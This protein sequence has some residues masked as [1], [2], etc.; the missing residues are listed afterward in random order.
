MIVAG[1]DHTPAARLVERSG[2]RIA[3]IMDV[4]PNSID[5]AVGFSNRRAGHEIGHY[6]LARG[7]RRFGYVGHDWSADL[8]ARRRYDGLC[9]ALALAGLG[10]VEQAI[11]QSP[12]SA[13]CGTAMTAELLERA[14]NVD[15]IVFSNDDM[16][17]GG[18]FHC[19]KA[20]IA[21]P[22]QVAVFGFNGSA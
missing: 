3:E 16:A 2:I 6:L 15:C 18:L 13:V 19:M 1:F 14:P 7:Y 21:V 5:L 4:D 20:G 17:F 8:R 10:I 9:E 22:G 12:S 11:A